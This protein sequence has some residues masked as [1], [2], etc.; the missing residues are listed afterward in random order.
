L[1]YE[2][3]LGSFS[4]LAK[5]LRSLDQD[6]GVRMLGWS[7]KRRALVFVTRF[8]RGYMVMTYAMKRGGAPGTRLQAVELD[9]ADKVIGVLRKL[10]KGRLQA[11]IY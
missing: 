11:W 7:G 6:A 4:G 9:G 1:F 3:E 10:A 5:R 8:E 2:E